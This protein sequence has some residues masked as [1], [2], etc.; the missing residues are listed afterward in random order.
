MVSTKKYFLYII[1]LVSPISLTLYAQNTAENPTK[2][3]V[4][5]CGLT[6]DCTDQNNN[7]NAVIESGKSSNLNQSIVG[8][9]TPKDSL[10]IAAESNTIS[11]DCEENSSFAA[12]SILAKEVI[13][14]YKY[15]FSETFI[16]IL[17]FERIDL[18]RTRTI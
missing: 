7:N 17:F 10:T 12:T 3:A 8:M 14:N 13:E 4:S 11:N 9:S 1:F 16:D 6:L 2:A 18:A 5:E 15:D